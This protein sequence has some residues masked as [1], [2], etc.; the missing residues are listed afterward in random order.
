M[1]RE[2][3]DINLNNGLKL[4]EKL[5]VNATYIFLKHWICFCDYSLGNIE[6]LI[7]ESIWLELFIQK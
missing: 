3:G 7:V 1:S 5:H 4:S 2:N 6:F